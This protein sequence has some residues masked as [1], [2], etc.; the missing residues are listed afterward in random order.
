[1]SLAT[2]FGK[3]QEHEME[4]LRLNQHEENDKKN[5]LFKRM[6]LQLKFHELL[7]DLQVFA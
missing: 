2:L 4:L 5:Y 3:L 1:M 6:I 7:I